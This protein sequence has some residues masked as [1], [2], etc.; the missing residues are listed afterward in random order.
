MKRAI[1]LGAI[2]SLSWS[3]VFV[4]GRYLCDVLGIHPILIAFLRFSCAG[5]ISIVYIALKGQ[6]R[7][8]S[9]LIERPLTIIVLALTGIAG[10]GST[11]FLALSRST[12]VDVSIIMN[13][14]TIFIIPLATLIGERFTLRN[15]IGVIIGLLGCALII[16]GGF[17][18]FQL[19]HRENFIGNLIALVA[20]ICWAVYTV[21]GK[22]LV[23]ERGGLVVTSLNMVVG[24]V[25][26]FFLVM[27]LGELT[28]PPLKASLVILYLA[29]FPTALG[30]VLWYKALEELDASQLGPL[31]YLVPIGTAIIA[32]FFLD[33]SIQLASIFGMLL[34]FLGIYLSTIASN[35][36]YQE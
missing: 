27:G 5:A 3:T 22:H 16:N 34:I 6:A 32:I 15:G 36:A 29:I 18:G 30:F 4:F 21:I 28:I 23:R 35:L 17:T 10:M 31:Q 1:L 12:S 20:A 25:P 9:L 14:N 24:S 7:D 19:A 26:L 11:V 13:S 8:L 2:A 33:E